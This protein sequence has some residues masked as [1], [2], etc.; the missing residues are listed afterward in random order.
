MA[1][2]LRWTEALELT[3]SQLYC[4]YEAHIEHDARA[5]LERLLDQRLS[6]G[7]D[8]EKGTAAKAFKDT[9][10]ALQQLAGYTDKP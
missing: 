6:T 8:D 5:R 2:V 1:G 3:L 10:Q 7:F 9:V 4:L